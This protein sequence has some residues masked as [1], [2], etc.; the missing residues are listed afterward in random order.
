MADEN[1]KKAKDVIKPE[2]ISKEVVVPKPEL[3]VSDIIAKTVSETFKALQPYLN[4][5]QAP[6][7]QMPKQKISSESVR[8]QIMREMSQE[9]DRKVN[10][11]R[12]FL[13]K[14]AATPRKDMVVY[15]IPMVYRQWIGQ[16][17]S[18][19]LNGSVITIPVNNRGYLI[20]KVYKPIIDQ[21]LRYEDEKISY[22][23]DND[24]KDI[25]YGESK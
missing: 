3:D 20:P 24:N 21:M 16:T 8:G 10:Q 12:K 7:P 11:N 6:A 4:Q 19:S 25:R 15:T 22:M 17:L 14:M 1:Q 9:F 5:P 23:T 2:D 18:V 13:E